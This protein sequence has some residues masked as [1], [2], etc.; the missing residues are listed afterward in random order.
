MRK[1][2]YLLFIF[3]ISA[4]F[5]EISSRILFK[6]EFNNYNRRVMLFSEN[7]TF[8]N[9]KNI[10]FYKPN[11]KFKSMTI[12]KDFQTNKLVEEY[13]YQVQ[14]NNAGLVQLR[15][16]E[17]KKNSIFLLGASATKG[18]GALPW[19]YDLENNFVNSDFQ[20]VNIGMIGT[21]PTQQNL[22][23]EYI[24]NNYQLS[25]DKVIIIFSAGS[26]GGGIWN[27]NKQQLECLDNQINCIG[28][29]GIYGFN[30][31]N[32]DPIIFSKKIIDS[33]KNNLNAFKASI[34]EKNYFQAIKE[35]AKKSYFV[36]KLYLVIRMYK[37]K[38]SS[39]DS[40]F[41]SVIRMQEKYS[42]KLY[43][44]HMQSKTES[45]ENKMNE[46]SI[47]VRNWLKENNMIKKNYLYCKI[48]TNGFHK[49][50]SHANNIGY[51]LLRKCVERVVNE[52]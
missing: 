36:N 51:K 48:P 35:I 47:F 2:Y 40:N 14:T 45:A 20:L 5:L 18:Q 21:G 26:F 16:L 12:Y 44:I 3:L 31:K 41:N 27:F 1:I 46:N 33:R 29:E 11:Q 37:S 24:K 43:L 50:D 42:D 7:K 39:N 19:F 17:M 23:F 34:K 4:V 10:F 22:L 8:K 13:S 6:D 52:K 32:Y 49:N 28:T 9:F 15:D 25:V 30:F 38:N